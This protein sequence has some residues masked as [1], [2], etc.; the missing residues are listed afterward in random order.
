MDLLDRIICLYCSCKP[1]SRYGDDGV[2]SSKIRPKPPAICA[3]VLGV[4]EED[5][6]NYLSSPRPTSYSDSQVLERGRELGKAVECPILTLIT[7]GPTK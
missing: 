4:K 3:E 6:L 7:G 2:H 5:R 1:V